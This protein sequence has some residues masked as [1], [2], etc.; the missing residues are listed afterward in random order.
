MRAPK[1]AIWQARR[2]KYLGGHVPKSIVDIIYFIYEDIEELRQFR[3]LSEAIKNIDRGSYNSCYNRAVV[4]PDKLNQYPPF[5]PQVYGET[6]FELIYEMI[7]TVKIS[8]DDSF[9]DLGSG[10]GQVVLQVAA[11]SDAKFCYG[12]EKADYPAVCASNMD[13]EFRR[14]M[15]FYGKSYRPYLVRLINSRNLFTKNKLFHLVRNN[16]RNFT[17][18][19]LHSES[20]FKVFNFVSSGIFSQAASD[21]LESLAIFCA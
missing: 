5:S 6:S 11:C 15:S 19:D 3:E 17:S 12:I 7:E 8:S 9:I 18:G 2:R 16:Q 21:H 20:S 13:A 4:E 14:W 10:V 1:F